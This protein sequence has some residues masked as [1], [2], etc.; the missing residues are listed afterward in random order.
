MG[1]RGS[2]H[3]RAHP[4]PV[5]SHSANR[6]AELNMRR[7]EAGFEMVTEKNSEAV[8]VFKHAALTTA[9]LLSEGR[10]GDLKVVG[11][12]LIV[13]C[14]ADNKN[15]AY[16][17]ASATAA[18]FARLIS[19]K[20]G[21]HFVAAFTGLD[22]VPGE[23]RQS[24]FTPLF[25]TVWIET[26]DPSRFS[27][28]VQS[29]GAASRLDD[30]VLDSALTYF[31]RGLFYYRVVWRHI[32]LRSPDP[33]FTAAAAILNFHHAVKII[34]GDDKDGRR[35]RALGVKRILRRKIEQLYNRRTHQGVAHPTLDV[36]AIHRL[37]DSVSES[38]T[39]ARTIIE[40]YIEFL[41]GGGA[42]P[43]ASRSTRQRRKK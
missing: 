33:D 27:G 5:V 40:T 11:N 8:D 31:Q 18:R 20:T 26:Y 43:Q 35:G 34:L 30:P 39:I 7:Y 2:E 38:Q 24:I 22:S 29:S 25:M 4:A 15:D 28:D 12:R 17:W 14:D 21:Q 3:E 10:R 1:R 42:L 41:R 13:S 16:A 36:D 9:N 37:R 23:S 32:D 19:M 6:L